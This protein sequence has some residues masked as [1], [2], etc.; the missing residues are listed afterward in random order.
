VICCIIELFE[1]VIR[2]RGRTRKENE[3]KDEDGKRWRKVRKIKGDGNIKGKEMDK[4]KRRVQSWKKRK[5]NMQCDISHIEN[6][7]VICCMIQSFVSAIGRE[8]F[9]FE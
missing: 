8:E 5:K 1:D 6:L 4:K 7:L 2:G 9:V 3:K